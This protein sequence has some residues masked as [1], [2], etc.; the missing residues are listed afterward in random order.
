MEK[1]GSA[2]GSRVGLGARGC[3]AGSGSDTMDLSFSSSRLPA[4]VTG[5]STSCEGQPT[6]PASSPIRPSA[7]SVTSG[8]GSGRAR[9]ARH[10]AKP[11]SGAAMAT[12][13]MWT[14]SACAQA[15]NTG[16]SA[17]STGS[18]RQWARHSIDRPMAEASAA[19][20]EDSFMATSPF[21]T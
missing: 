2:G 6:A 19:W 12:N 3:G 9:C 10:S 14:H 20:V 7:A 18:S 5:V 8:Q 17:A 4:T 13:T 11:A 21:V 16:S 15:P 1:V